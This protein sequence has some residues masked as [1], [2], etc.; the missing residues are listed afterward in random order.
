MLYVDRGQRK[1]ISEDEKVIDFRIIRNTVIRMRKTCSL[2]RMTAKRFV[3]QLGKKLRIS[4]YEL[5]RI[6]E[7]RLFR[8]YLRLFYFSVERPRYYQDREFSDYYYQL[9]LAA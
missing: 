8:L 9:Y 6:C 7:A 4:G 2:A 5:G 1:T 3:K